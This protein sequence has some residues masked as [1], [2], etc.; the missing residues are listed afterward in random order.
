MN[1]RTKII[2]ALTV[3][4]V[5]LLSSIGIWLLLG[6]SDDTD[7]M[8]L[9]SKPA[10]TSSKIGIAYSVIGTSERQT[11]ECKNEG[12]S[13]YPIYGQALTKTEGES[14][15]EFEEL[16]RA[17]LSENSY[18]NADPAASLLGDC[19]NYDSLDS[20]GYLYL[21][22]APVLDS[23]G[24]P[25]RLYKHTAAENMYYGN[26]SDTEAAVIK[27]IKIS[28]RNMGNYITGLYAPAGEVMKL[29]ISRSDLERIGGFNIYV[30]ATLANGQANNIWL[31]RDFNRM[32]VI[33]NKMPV[34]SDV[35]SYDEK[36]DSYICYFGSYLGGPIYI[37]S[38]T[39]KVDFQVEISGGVEY[40]HLIW[41]LTTEEE[42][43]RYLKS[44]APYFDLEVF[45]N[46]VRFSGP[47]LYSDKYSYAE[48]CEAAELWDKI[49]RVSKEVPSASNSSYGIDFLFDPFV[50]AGAAVAF[51]GRNTVNCPPS[52]I[53]GCLDVESFTASGSWGNIHEFNHHFQKFGLPNGGEVTN[54]AVSL[55]EYSLFTKISSSRTLADSSLSGWNVYTDASRA[56]RI[57][58]DNSAA[59][60]PVESLD[61][62][63]TILHSF[64]Q[65][66]F[67]AATKDG[68]GTDKWFKNL[69]SLTHYDLTYYFTEILHASVSEDILAEVRELGYPMYVPVACI[70]QT[71]TKYSFDDEQKHITTVQPFEFVGEYYDFSVAS[72]LKIPSGFTVTD[73]SVGSSQYGRIERLGDDLYRFIPSDKGISGDIDVK[74][75]L[76]RDDSAFSVEDIT[77]VLGFKKQTKKTAERV[78]YYFDEDISKLFDDIDDAVD[79]GYAGYTSSETFDTSESAVWWTSE[80]VVLNSI[81]EYTSKIF[82][83][84]SGTYR[85]SLRGKN[86]ALYVSLDGEHY[87]YIA[88]AGTDYNNRFDVS[89]SL[90]EYK[91]YDL[92][93]GQSVYIKAVVMH[94]DLN[95][96]ALVV[97]MGAVTS[98]GNASIDYLNRKTTVYN[99]NYQKEKFESDYFIEREYTVDGFG[100]KTDPTSSVIDTNFSPWDD[101]TV[102]EN[103][104]D[105]NSSTYMH[106][107]QYEYVTENS[108]FEITVDLGRAI[109]ANRITM[110]GR[111]KNTQTPISY[112]LYGGI[113]PDNMVL[114]CEYEDEPLKNSCN[115]IGEFDLTELRYYKLVVTKTNA[116]YI[117]LSGIEFGVDFDGGR[118]ISPDTSDVSYYGSWEAVYDL[119]TFGHTYATEDGYLELEFVGTQIAVISSSESPAE[120]VVSIDGGDARTV[121]FDGTGELLLLSDELDN[122]RHKIVIRTSSKIGIDSFAV[123]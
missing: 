18:L 71:G 110:Y 108:P 117:C 55:V 3:L 49:A 123:R 22:G 80:G 70:Y 48:L 21:N 10:S 45:D 77:L 69:C 28:P 44:S 25:R 12:L 31:A 24:N 57:L 58:L 65:E 111:Y 89:V 66:V 90:G 118:L 8:E 107:K 41:G 94:T 68:S 40:P 27:Q 63:A 81:S 105:G 78:T 106:N 109:K 83:S 67:I 121:K 29:T 85:F 73:V 16:K 15:E 34:N 79:K 59:G 26:V 37:G 56:L 101:T 36:T 52:W 92:T 95:S 23:D 103:L 112:Q 84:E 50:A 116:N 93:R 11:A 38:P 75:S 47:R 9:F 61:A 87:E 4:F 13:R 30:G 46:T 98:D 33:S 17:I 39:N 115:Q 64:G 51:V 54:N 122:E 99:I 114:L 120:L 119:S 86:A 100:I 113:D 104:F 2:V 6:E 76:K 42:Y 72:L 88:K 96:C 91:D 35:C 53:D 74:L 5:L 19:T 20:D 97:G 14:D 7:K 43:N 102:L 62:Y 60:T 32:P 1:R 82:I